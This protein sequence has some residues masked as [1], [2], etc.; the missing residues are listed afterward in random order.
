VPESPIQAKDHTNSAILQEC[1]T[2][3]ARIDRDLQYVGCGRIDVY[4]PNRFMNASLII[5][6]TRAI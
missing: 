1:D 5:S 6:E 4:P 2:E 3:L